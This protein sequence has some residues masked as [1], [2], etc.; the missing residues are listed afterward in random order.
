MSSLIRT[1]SL[2]VI[3]R[4]YRFGDSQ[5]NPERVDLS[6]PIQ[7]VHDASRH[8]EVGS[9]LSAAGAGG[10][11]LIGSNHAHPGADTQYSVDNPRTVI[12]AGIAAGV[13]PQNSTEFAV[14]LLDVTAFGTSGVITSASSQV[15]FPILPGQTST[16]PLPVFQSGT[17][18][19]VNGGASSDLDAVMNLGGAGLNAP[20]LIPDG[21]TFAK[22]SV[23]AGAGNI[24]IVHRCWVGAAGAL[25]PGC[26]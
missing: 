22:R 21:A 24:R 17:V 12:A 23:S 16:T 9:G 25:P 1:V 14:W 19:K 6:A 18:F 3:N 7:I 11:W 20:M 10:V 26:A 8:A 4:L 13:I 5:Q 2:A 15:L